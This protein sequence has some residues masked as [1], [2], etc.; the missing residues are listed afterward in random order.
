MHPLTKSAESVFRA[1]IA[2][3]PANHSAVQIGEKDGC[4]MPLH[5]ERIGSDIYQGQRIPLISFAHYYTQNG[6]LMRDPDVVMQDH[7]AGLLC[8][9]TFRQ[10]GIGVDQDAREFDDDGNVIG[11]NA[12]LQ[13]GLAQFCDTWARNLQ[14]QQNL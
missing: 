8:P 14:A 7:G 3:I 9:V 4:F 1:A 10:D 2:R 12:L 6:D 5:V 13:N 11:F